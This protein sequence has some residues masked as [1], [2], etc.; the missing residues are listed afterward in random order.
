MLRRKRPHGLTA[1]LW[2]LER[3]L[4]RNIQGAA[5]SSGPNSCDRG[6][7][8]DGA[9]SLPQPR[10]LGKLSVPD[11]ISFRPFCVVLE[12]ERVCDSERGRQRERAGMA[13]LVI[14][15]WTHEWMGICTTMFFLLCSAAKNPAMLDERRSEPAVVCFVGQN[16]HLYGKSCIDHMEYQDD[17]E[18]WAGLKEDHPCSGNGAM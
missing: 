17:L 12:N 16:G 15:I 18:R 7:F 6:R 14:T 5:L 8:D 11:D 9:N 10:P 2:G 3:P 1:R 4:A 13:G